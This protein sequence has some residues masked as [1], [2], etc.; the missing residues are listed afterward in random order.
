VHIKFSVLWDPVKLS[1]S[2]NSK[3]F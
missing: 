2:Q 3:L 1:P